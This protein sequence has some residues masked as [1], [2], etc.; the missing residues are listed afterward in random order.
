MFGQRTQRG[1]TIIEVSMV[2]A[3]TGFLFVALL[4]GIGFAVE[5]QRFS[6]TVFSLQSYLQLQYN[7]VVN[8]VNNRKDR[9]SCV[10]PTNTTTGSFVGTDECTILGRAIV[11]LYDT[12]LQATIIKTYVVIGTKEP[13][14]SMSMDAYES[15]VAA[16]PYIIGDSISEDRYEVA[17]GGT[18]RDIHIKDQPLPNPATSPF[19]FAILRSPKSGAVD[20]YLLRSNLGALPAD[21]ILQT[22]TTS[23]S[24]RRALNTAPTDSYLQAMDKDIQACI[25]SSSLVGITA[26][27]VVQPTGSQDGVLTFFDEERDGVGECS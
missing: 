15:I 11:V 22:Q 1:F 16:E 18:V 27:L 3:I 9:Q 10:D 4:S 7:E 21:P 17:W 12:S 24:W 26:A 13:D 2:V 8:V 19:M 23:V 5:R 25:E 14:T 20:T 6:D